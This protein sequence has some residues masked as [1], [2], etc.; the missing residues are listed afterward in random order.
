[1]KTERKAEDKNKTREAILDATENIMRKDGYAAVSSRRVANEAGLKS[2][3]VHYHFGTMD[4]LFLALFQ[5]AD[6]QNFDRHMRAMASTKPLRELWKLNT[7][8]KG[9]GLIFE[10]MALANHRETLRKEI[11]RANV[12]TRSLQNSIL[13]RA[14]EE[15]GISID[16]FPPNVVSLLMAGA[17]LELVTEA[18]IGVHDAHSDTLAFVDKLLGKTELTP[19]IDSE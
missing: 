17:A 10:F 12:R 11:A 6:S 19:L 4:E 5:R 13:K 1:M 8:R 15:S 9:M 3:L 2:Q 16:Q 18:S 7:D 14:F